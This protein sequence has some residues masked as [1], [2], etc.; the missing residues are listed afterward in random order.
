MDA[1]LQPLEPLTSPQPDI[2]S[3]TQAD[4]QSPANDD[5]FLLHFHDPCF[6]IALLLLIRHLRSEN[7]ELRNQAGYWQ[8]M[9]QRAVERE[10]KLAQEVQ[11]LQAEIRELNKRFF[12]R[13]DGSGEERQIDL[14][15]LLGSCASRFFG[16]AHQ[17][18]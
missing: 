4:P 2:S 5:D 8:A 17:L 1:I 7:L 16:G 12:G 10:Q 11:Q 13:S 3:P 9:H 6:P 15:L 18:A 14:G